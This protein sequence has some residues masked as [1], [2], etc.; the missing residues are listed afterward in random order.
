MQIHTLV[1]NSKTACRIVFLSDIHKSPKDADTR[2]IQNGNFKTISN[3][4]QHL[5]IRIKF[6]NFHAIFFP[7]ASAIACRNSFVFSGSWP[8]TVFAGFILRER[9]V[10]I[11]VQQHRM[12]HQARTVQQFISG[13]D[14]GADTTPQIVGLCK[15]NKSS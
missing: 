1:K 3:A 13:L 4:H 15:L 14:I 5:Q 10:T 12:Y 7:I 9:P 6:V 11:A 8:A 2:N